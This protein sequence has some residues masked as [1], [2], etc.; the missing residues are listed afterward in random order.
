MKL[1]D[2]KLQQIHSVLVAHGFKWINTDRVSDDWKQ[3]IY[4]C[5]KSGLQLSI[6]DRERISFRLETKEN[7]TDGI[8]LR[9]KCPKGSSLNVSFSNFKNNRGYCYY[10]DNVEVFSK[11]VDTYSHTADP[12]E[13]QE[14]KYSYNSFE[15]ILTD[16][17]STVNKSLV[18]NAPDR[19]ARLVKSRKYP[20]TST[21]T[22]TVYSR[23]PDV[24]AHVLIRAD[25]SCEQC[26]EPAPFI[27]R[28]NSTP[29]LEVHHVDPLSNGGE[30]T[31]DN[32]IALCPNCHREAHYGPA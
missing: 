7:P 23:N 2:S 11:F 17:Q 24:V 13:L 10:A 14:D 5:R 31:I 3:R 29:Y 19:N 21:A 15:K 18:D 26:R 6:M 20:T 16:F 12:I 32:A 1:D 9:E 28:S 25:G 27:R 22:I 4:E 30:D 8:E